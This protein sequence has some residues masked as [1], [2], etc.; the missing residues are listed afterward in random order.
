[1]ESKE[2]RVNVNKVSKVLLENPDL[3]EWFKVKMD[4]TTNRVLEAR[5]ATSDDPD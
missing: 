2:I 3:R 5:K 1:M 4:C